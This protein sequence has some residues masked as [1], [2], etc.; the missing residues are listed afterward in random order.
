VLTR[1]GQVLQAGD[2]V[3]HNMRVD[4]LPGDF[5]ELRVDAGVAVLIDWTEDERY[6]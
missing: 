3:T 5:Y 2:S 6:Q 1:A 4:V